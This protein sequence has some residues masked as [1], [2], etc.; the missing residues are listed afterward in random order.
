MCGFGVSAELAIEGAE[1]PGACDNIDFRGSFNKASTYFHDVFGSSG[2]EGGGG[3]SKPNTPIVD[4]LIE[5]LFRN[6][7]APASSEADL[8]D[9]ASEARIKL[10]NN[11]GII[12]VLEKQLMMFSNT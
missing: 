12:F 2:G 8:L 1:V 5:Q 7:T 4:D 10:V 11:P 9:I 3:G 6:R